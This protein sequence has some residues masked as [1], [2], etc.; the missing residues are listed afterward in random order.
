MNV[1][2]YIASGKLEAYVLGELSEAEELE[3]L[4]LA[5]EYPEIRQELDALERTQEQLAFENAVAPPD[6]VRAKLFSQLNFEETASEEPVTAPEEAR[7]SPSTAFSQTTRR[8]PRWVPVGMAAAITWIVLS[9]GAALYFWQQWQ[10]TLLGRE[11][12]SNK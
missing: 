2:R 7:Q 6:S 5:S 12:L 11:S 3:V 1:E 4:R 9:T 10:Q 8:L